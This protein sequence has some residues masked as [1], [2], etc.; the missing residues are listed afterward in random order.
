MLTR[1]YT[2]YTSAGSLESDIEC[3]GTSVPT[4]MALWPTSWLRQ[5]LFY[6]VL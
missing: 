5:P 1:T 4:A 6:L 2:S 3:T